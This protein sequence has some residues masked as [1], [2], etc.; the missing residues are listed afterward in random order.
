[1]YT[2]SERI[3]NFAKNNNPNIGPGTYQKTEEYENAKTQGFAPFSSLQ[4]RLSLFSDSANNP[5]PNEYNTAPIP[6]DRAGRV[7]PFGRSSR[8]TNPK[9]ISPGPATY[10]IRQKIGSEI[11]KL[12]PKLGK[13]TMNTNVGYGY[14]PEIDYKPISDMVK[15]N[16]ENNTTKTKKPDCEDKPI[17]S[18]MELDEDEEESN[19]IIKNQN[20]LSNNLYKKKK[21]KEE[22]IDR[23]NLIW[24]RKFVTPSIP[25]KNLT[26]GFIENKDGE[27]EPRKPPENDETLGPAYYNITNNSVQ[28]NNVYRGGFTFGNGLKEREAFHVN[29]DVPGPGK[30]NITKDIE[31]FKKKNNASALMKY[32]PCVRFSEAVYKQEIKK[33]IPGPGAYKTN[34]VPSSKTASKRKELFL[35]GG[36]DERFKTINTLCNVQKTIKDNCA[37][38][39]GTY[40][41]EHT[42]EYENNY[43]Y[44]TGSKGKSALSKEDRFKDNFENSLMPG[45]GQ[46][47]VKYDYNPLIR[48]KVPTSK[49]YGFGTT[50]K[51]FPSSKVSG[52][53]GPG[54][55]NYIGDSFSKTLTDVKD[56]YIYDEQS[57]LKTGIIVN[58]KA[59]NLS[60]IKMNKPIKGVNKNI[61]YNDDDTAKIGFGTQHD[62]FSKYGVNDNPAPGM[63]DSNK[64]FNLLKSHGKIGLTL[65][66][67]FNL[68]INNNRLPPGLYNPSLPGRKNFHVPVKDE[69]FMGKSERF[70][71]KD[72]K[73]PGPSDY[74]SPHYDG[75]NNKN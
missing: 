34:I 65:K 71:Y 43:L 73:L 28:S 40:D 64:A 31:L 1:M 15:D 12:G 26:Y 20:P 23:C 42:N 16:E 47:N 30:Y 59:N 49:M 41:I 60:K 58:Q 63:Y 38:G 19:I 35:F 5:S 75:N 11:E 22:N 17:N 74:L 27:I 14:T 37:P 4:P 39:P 62:R 68:N 53:P 51:R 13:L 50:S 52:N 33:N 18:T 8:F 69:T 57:L 6:L 56:P 25:Y 3:I 48:H 45:P 7:V 54:Q 66:T 72:N 70:D 21:V 32:A 55:Y 67:R 44:H 36:K 29:K 9:N 10:N 61:I 46:Y 24:K 2:R